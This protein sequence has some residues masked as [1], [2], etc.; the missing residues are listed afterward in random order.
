MDAN[1]FLTQQKSFSMARIWNPLVW[2]KNFQTL[3]HVIA[4]LIAYERLHATN[5]WYCYSFAVC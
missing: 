1:T 3:V 2:L 5:G 4:Y